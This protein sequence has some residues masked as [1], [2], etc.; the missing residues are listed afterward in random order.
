MYRILFFLLFILSFFGAYAQNSSQFVLEDVN[1][2]GNKWTKDFVILR[3]LN[4]KKGQTYDIQY[5]NEAKLENLE[6]LKNL[7]LFNDVEMEFDFDSTDHKFNIDIKIVENWYIW[8]SPIFELADRN[9]A[10]WWTNQNRDFTRVNYGLR[11]DHINLTGRRDRLIFQLQSGFRKK[12]ELVYNQPYL[13]K[14]GTMGAEAFI[15]FANQDQ[16]PY[17]TENNRTVFGSFEERT[18]LERF[19][20]GGA[21]FYRPT[22][23]HHHAFRLEY[24]KNAVDEYVIQELNPNYFLDGRTSIQFFMFNYHYTYDKRISQFIPVDGYLLWADIKKEGFGIFNEYNN[25]SASIGGEYYHPFSESKK[26]VFGTVWKAKANLDRRVVSF[27]NNTGIGWGADQLGGYHLYVVDGTDY[28][29]SRNNLRYK[30]FDS[31]FNLGKFMPFH[32]FR[33]LNVQLY[34]RVFLDMAYVNDPTYSSVFNNDFNNRLL[35]GWG[36]GADMLLFNNYMFS[37][38]LGINHLNELYVFFQYRTNF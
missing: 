17:K 29:Y 36:P 10:E 2:S 12:Y 23:Y 26:L 14:E 37:Y 18:L 33:T 3:E 35:W 31:K 21:F 22:I 19:R 20:T 6:R 34:G 7:G 5:I 25:T 38:N 30:F 4:F 1:I 11:I 28:V 15:F 9:F 16:I 8:P 24:H 13:N 27:A 32:Q